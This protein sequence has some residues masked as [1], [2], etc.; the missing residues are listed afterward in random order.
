MLKDSCQG[1]G[2]EKNPVVSQ[3]APVSHFQSVSC[4]FLMVP[5]QREYSDSLSALTALMDSR[6]TG[7]FTD[8]HR[9]NDSR[10]C[11]FL[12]PSLCPFLLL[13]VDPLALVTVG[14]H[15]YSY[16]FHSDTG[17][18]C[19]HSAQRNHELTC[20]IDTCSPHCTEHAMDGAA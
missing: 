13:M 19:Q 5:V 6:A 9:Q 16:T 17:T 18:S 20:Y 7:N 10:S 15:W 4:K 2:R 11:Y 8:Q 1:G 14:T 3:P 12:C